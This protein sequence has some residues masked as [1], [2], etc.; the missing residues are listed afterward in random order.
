MVGCG[1]AAGIAAT[2]N[3]PIAGVL[4][5]LEVLLGD[6]GLA[7]FS[8]VVLSS[9]TATI[10]SRHYFGDFPAF[11]IPSYEVASLW[12]FC[13]YPFLGVLAGLVAI[14]FIILLYKTEDLFQA[15]K[16]PEWLKP[17]LG[18]V[19]LGLIL[20]KCPYVFGVGYGAINKSLMVELPGLL[21][22]ALIFMKIVSTSIT[23]GSGGSGGVFAPSL[24]IGAMAGGFFGWGVNMLFPNVTASP[25]AYAL[26]GMGAVVAGTTH[27]PITA[28]LIIFEMTGDYAIVL[29]MMITCILSTILASSLKDGS[30]YTIK[31]LR[32]GVDISGGLERNILRAMKVKDFMGGEVTTIREAMNLM[33]LVNTFKA[34]DVSYVHVVNENSDLT[35]II[36]FR[37]IRPLLQEEGNLHHLIIAKDVATTDLATVKPEDNMQ[38]ALRTMSDRGISQLPVLGGDNGKKVIA[39]LRERDV[40]AA[41][42]KALIRREIEMG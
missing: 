25:G 2:F 42:D 31:L 1:A 32:R 16:I 24:F 18:G 36:S 8:P 23:I 29:P 35:G 15:L 9:V 10:I 37:D 14:V 20:L 22:L 7:A 40:F 39:T 30:I 28:I 19:A 4:F 38:N 17:A 12:E 13:I 33:D 5:A 26:I 6:F 11:V 3:A 27:A 21:L 34:E 41:Y